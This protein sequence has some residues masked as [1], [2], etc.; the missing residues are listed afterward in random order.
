MTMSETVN[1]SQSENAKQK[2][3]EKQLKEIYYDPS[4]PTGLGSIVALAAAANVP[5]AKTNW[6]MKRLIY[7]LYRISL[8][9]YPTRKYE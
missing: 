3:Q 4:H 5:V 9:R 7:T 6:L 1:H 2:E 8:K